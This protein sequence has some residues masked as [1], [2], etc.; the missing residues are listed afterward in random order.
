MFKKIFEKLK[1]A[2]A[3]VADKVKKAIDWVRNHK[4]VVVAAIVGGLACVAAAGF[5]SMTH[6]PNMYP[7][8]STKA[9]VAEDK[10]RE[11]WDVYEKYKDVH[12]APIKN[13]Y[14]SG[15]APLHA[16][17][18]G[19]DKLIEFQDGWWAHLKPALYSENIGGAYKLENLGEMGNDLYSAAE[20]SGINL[21]KN[22]KIDDIF[23]VIN[24][25]PP[26][27]TNTV[28]QEGNDG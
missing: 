7:D 26:I 27:E 12:N 6:D 17:E 10:I 19:P 3:W 2:A 23:M 15:D 24:K 16:Y 21:P 13:I 22:S 25:T 20:R 1:K 28:E 4:E 14:W 5:V 9:C 8:I 11:A 18:I